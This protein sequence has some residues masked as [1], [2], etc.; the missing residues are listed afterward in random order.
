MENG[1]LRDQ[2]HIVHLPNTNLY[3]VFAGKGWHNW[4][5]VLV[6]AEF[7]RVIKGEKIPAKILYKLFEV[8]QKE[9]FDQQQ[10][11]VEREVA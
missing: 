5:R 9:K 7:V 3:D 4:S 11:R 2:F 1:H 8:E 6:K 10:S